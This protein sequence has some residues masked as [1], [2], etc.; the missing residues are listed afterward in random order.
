MVIFFWRKV[1][2]L[3]RT[4]IAT[5]L[6]H[7]T[8]GCSNGYSSLACKILYIVKKHPLLIFFQN[9]AEIIWTPII[10]KLMWFEQILNP[11]Q[12]SN[13]MSS[14]VSLKNHRHKKRRDSLEAWVAC[15]WI[16]ILTWNFVGDRDDSTSVFFK[17]ASISWF[18]CS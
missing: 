11:F 2:N 17:L 18:W 14:T 10:Q 7:R 8:D 15:S 12:D 9:L 6:Q 13:Y 16:L 3:L 5:I 4:S 1:M